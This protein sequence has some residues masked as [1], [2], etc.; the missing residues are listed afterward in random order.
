MLLSVAIRVFILTQG[1]AGDQDLTC[2]G[3]SS[4]F[5]QLPSLRRLDLAGAHLGE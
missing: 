2:S 1:T 3:F 5:A 4:G